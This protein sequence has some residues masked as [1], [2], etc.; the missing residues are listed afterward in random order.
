MRAGQ[1]AARGEQPGPQQAS[2]RAREYRVHTICNILGRAAL[3][4]FARWGERERASRVKA[5]DTEN[6]P[7]TT[8]A[9]E[10]DVD[11]SH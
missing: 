3:V 8:I 4:L 9:S 7:L 6:C 2:K 11:M 5:K 10:R 1:M